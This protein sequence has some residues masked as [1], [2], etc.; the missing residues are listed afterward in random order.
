MIEVGHPILPRL[1]IVTVVIWRRPQQLE[2]GLSGEP[3]VAV[4]MPKQDPHA[5]INAPREFIGGGHN[6]RA[7]CGPKP[8]DRSQAAGSTFVRPEN[9]LQRCLDM[10]PSFGLLAFTFLFEGDSL[11][12][13]LGNGPVAVRFQHLPSVV[14]N[15]DFLHHHGVMLLFFGATAAPHHSPR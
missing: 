14:M 15:V 12:S 9:R 4:L 7:P 2:A 1:A 6:Q 5:I 13:G 10:P 11:L 8:G 3:S